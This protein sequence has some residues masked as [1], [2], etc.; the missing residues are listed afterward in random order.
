MPSTPGRS[1]GFAVSAVAA[2]AL[3]IAGALSP[4]VARAFGFEVLSIDGCTPIDPVNGCYADVITVRLRFEN[5]RRIPIAAVEGVARASRPGD[6]S[7][8]PGSP[9][10][11]SLLHDVCIPTFGCFDGMTNL[12]TTGTPYW[13]PDGG[14]VFLIGITP[15]VL[16]TADGIDSPGLDGI[17]G[18]G[19][20]QFEIS[21]LTRVI[22]S[23]R[24][25]F[26][27]DALSTEPQVSDAFRDS[28]KVE[29]VIYSDGLSPHV[30][31]PEP[32]M[33]PLLAFGALGVA[34]MGGA[35]RRHPRDR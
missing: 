5:D 10:V 31:V 20:A 11:S 16:H 13:A 26:E 3:L 29:I 15:G 18:G 22:G 9:V 34:A 14:L 25:R 33:A 27:L 24:V 17:V 32:A 1:R 19:D 28:A 7:F 6:I 8:D 23:A 35:R 30:V 2:L 12:P 21:F 4:T